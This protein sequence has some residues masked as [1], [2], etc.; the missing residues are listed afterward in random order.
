MIF[1]KQQFYI[2]GLGDLTPFIMQFSINEDNF[3]WVR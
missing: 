3:W 1:L 2:S